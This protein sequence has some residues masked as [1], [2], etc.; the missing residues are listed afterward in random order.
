[1]IINNVFVKYQYYYNYYNTKLNYD[2][3]LIKNVVSYYYYE[4]YI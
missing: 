4:K 3:N 2:T 1:M